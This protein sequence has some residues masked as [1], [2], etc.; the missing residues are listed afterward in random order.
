KNRDNKEH[1]VNGTVELAEVP[2]DDDVVPNESKHKS[3]LQSK[4][5]NLA[6]YIGYI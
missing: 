5:S 4:L 3:V 1:A 2:D 6:L